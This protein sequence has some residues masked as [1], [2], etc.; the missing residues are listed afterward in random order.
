MTVSTNTRV[1]CLAVLAVVGSVSLAAQQAVTLR[2]V[3]PKGETLRYKSTQQT[4][5]TISGAPGGMGDVTLD[6]TMIQVMRN[7]AKD[8]AADGTATVEQTIESVQ[9]DM[10][11]PMGKMGFDSATPKTASGNPI[12]EMMAKM[13]SGMINVPYSITLSSAGT[14]QKVEGVTKIAEKMFAAIPPNPQT[15]QVLGGL[16]ASMSDEGMV[17]T[18]SQA[19]PQLPAKAVKPGETWKGTFTVPNPAMGKLVYTYESTLQSVENQIAKV[20]TKLT[21]TQDGSGPAAG[22]MGLKLTLGTAS[23]DVDLQFDTAKGRMQKAVTRLA[24]PIMMSGAAPDG[25]ALNIKNDSK[26]TLT[27]ELMP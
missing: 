14:V 23:G 7:I 22:P 1:V 10:N 8:V 26:T 21:I 18:L 4:A 3:W 27:L 12:E 20:Q 2:Y 17:A 5:A 16:K 13:F 11:T 19:M 15:D 25:T 6:Q 24:M 9:M